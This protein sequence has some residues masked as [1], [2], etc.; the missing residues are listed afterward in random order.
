MTPSATE[1]IT[2]RSQPIGSLY[3]DEPP[4]DS[5]LHL[6]Q[7][8]LLLSSLDWRWRE[9]NDYFA[10]GNLTI[11]YSLKQLPHKWETADFH[12]P[13]FFVVLDTHSAHRKSWIVWEESGQYPNVIIELLSDATKHIDRGPKKKL[14]AETFRTPEYFWFDPEP[15]SLEFAGF[16]LNR[17]R[18]EPIQANESGL[19]WSDQLQLHLGVQNGQLRYFERSNELVPTPEEVIATAEAL[20]TERKRSAQLAEKLLEAEIAPDTV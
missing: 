14:Y 7:L 3:S 11:F 1:P 9:R 10:T 5:S 13:D 16:A 15:D 17:G 20:S 2:E 8:M 4:F 19:L 6:Q 18:Y 12:G